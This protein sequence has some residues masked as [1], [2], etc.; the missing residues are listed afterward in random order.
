MKTSLTWWNEVKASPSLLKDWLVK[1][2]R[3]EVTAAD[4]IRTLADN[5]AT[6]GLQ[7]KTLEVIAS[8]EETHAS[9]VLGLLNARGIMPCSENAEDRYWA[10]TL[11]GIEDFETGSAVAAHAE[12]MRLERIQVICEDQEAP[13]D[14]RSVFSRILKD[15]LFHE[16]AFRQMSTPAALAKT[17]DNHELGR[18]ALGLVA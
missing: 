17:Q 2:Y 5:Y 8:Q 4:R 11:P 9:W 14:I 15:E 12:K 6:T 10:A 18:T 13:E 7:R 1:Q 16:R 3:G